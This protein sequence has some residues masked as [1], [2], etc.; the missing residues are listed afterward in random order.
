MK[1]IRGFAG[2]MAA[3][4]LSWPLSA[5]AEI[6]I[7]VAGPMKGQFE[8]LG[9]QI[10]AGAE[11]AVVDI[12]MSGGVLGEPLVLDIVDD[13]CDE[14]QAKAVANQLIG[15]EVSMVVGHV[16]FSASIPASEIY[17]DAG[18]VQI[19]PATTLPKFT[20]ERPG[21]GIYRL[22]PR[23]DEQA[24]V[25]GQYLADAFAGQDIAL[26]HDKTAYGKGLTDAVRIV[27][28]QNG[29]TETLYEGFDAGLNDYR[30]LVSRLA[31]E[32]ADVVFIG[33]YHPEAGL[34]KLEMQ[35]LGVDAVLVG[36]DT[37]MTQAFWDVTGEAGEGT[38]FSYPLDPR[39][40]QTVAE[41]IEALESREEIAER[42]ALAAYAAVE[43]WAEAVEAAGAPDFVAVTKAMDEQAF[44]TILGDISF[45]EKG[46]SSILQFVIYEWKSGKPFER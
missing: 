30:I 24:R 28:N 37:L 40:L 33:G 45:D 10:R 25:L 17:S 36:G 31:L 39:S 43:A 11:Q 14:T 7:A 20:D 27:L 41:V 44:P 15:R 2:M 1:I 5:A 6:H 18:I 29:V 38:T 4:L 19:S 35:R 8:D 23:D 13:G 46:D 26:L 34:I 22:A 32:G 42:Y 21:S 9:Q 12:N 16:C 3:T